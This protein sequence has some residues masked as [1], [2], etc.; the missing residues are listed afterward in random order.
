MMGGEVK[1][2]LGADGRTG[3]FW[4]W[5]PLACVLLLVAA[6]YASG[7]HRYLSLAGI[8]KYHT[9]LAAFV[10][11]NAFVAAVAYMLVY[12]AAVGLSLPGASVLTAAGG[13]MFGC[14]LGTTL[15]AISA[16]IGA[17]I[18]FL[19][20]RTSIGVW[21]ATRA[22]PRLKRLRDGFQAD[23]FSYL[24]FLRLAPIFPFWIVNLAAAVFGVR[25]AQYV[26]ATAIGIL[27]GTIVFS[28]FGQGLDQA[29]GPNGRILSP[30]LLFALALL[31]V[32][33]LVPAVLRRYRRP[34]SSGGR[35]GQIGG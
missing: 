14:V 34:G 15:S 12:V 11:E 28:Y 2:R 18:I 22:G 26:L 32:M 19:I 33:A 23:G 10:A 9:Q 30:G 3:Q 35:S 17:T 20:A 16:T 13:F 5:L 24:L 6:V 31:A 4:R 8:G 1:H 27:P 29:L 21:L 25:P 7:L